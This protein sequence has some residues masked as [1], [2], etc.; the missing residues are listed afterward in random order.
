MQRHLLVEVRD[1]C[2]LCKDLRSIS[3]SRTTYFKVSLSSACLESMNGVMQLLN[4]LVL[5]DVDPS[6]K[7]T[8]LLSSD[9]IIMSLKKRDVLKRHR[10][11]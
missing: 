10:E 3:T 7:L 2:E 8:E 9:S 11:L 4:F 1:A 6:I 5:V